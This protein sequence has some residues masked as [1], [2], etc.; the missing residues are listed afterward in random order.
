LHVTVQLKRA[1]RCVSLC[2]CCS[3]CSS[4]EQTSTWTATYLTR[5]SLSTRLK[6]DPL[7]GTTMFTVGII[8]TRAKRAFN[9]PHLNLAYLRSSLLSPCTQIPLVHSCTNGSTVVVGPWLLLR[10]RNVFHTDGRTP[11]TSD[12]LLAKPL[13]TQDNTNIE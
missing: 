9:A 3:P 2:R 13:H 5:I 1:L 6:R 12:Q 4:T 11:W 8:S 7:F 10:F